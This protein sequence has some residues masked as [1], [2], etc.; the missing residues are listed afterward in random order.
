MASF[1]EVDRDEIPFNDRTYV[2]YFDLYPE[3][4]YSSALTHLE[5]LDAM[6]VLASSQNNEGWQIAVKFDVWTFW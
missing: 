2:D 3:R 5:S 4:R 6:T 1:L